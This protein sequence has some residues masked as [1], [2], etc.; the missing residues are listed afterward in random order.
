MWYS[1]DDILNI[2]CLSLYQHET[3]Q[4]NPTVLDSWTC[5][6]YTSSSSQA[7][8]ENPVVVLGNYYCCKSISKSWKSF[9]EPL[10]SWRKFLAHI[11]P[12]Q[13]VSHSQNFIFI[14]CLLSLIVAQVKFIK[15]FSYTWVYS[16][17]VSL[18]RE[19]FFPQSL[20]VRI[21]EHTNL[22]CRVLNADAISK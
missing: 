7:E 6:L 4:E 15:L 5:H 13:P 20:S 18:F 16:A 9:S 21:Y 2:S 3:V 1:P 10:P 22:F 17:I 19:V 12:S 14:P 11:T 8:T